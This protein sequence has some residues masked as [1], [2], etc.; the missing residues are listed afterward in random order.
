MT[1]KTDIFDAESFDF[2]RK[3]VAEYEFGLIDIR[4]RITVRV[5]KYIKPAPGSYD[6]ELSHEMRTPANP[7]APYRTSE[8][9][10]RT[11]EDTLRRAV[12]SITLYYEMAKRAG[13][14]P[15]TDWLVPNEY[16]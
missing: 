16:F 7:A 11:I 12:E 13:H 2:G 10:R 14:T 5:Y 1:I 8:R 15:S 9:S 3:L 6:F 4:Q